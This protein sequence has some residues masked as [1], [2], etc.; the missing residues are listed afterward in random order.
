[1]DSKFSVDDDVS[2]QELVARAGEISGEPQHVVRRVLAAVSQIAHEG[3]RHGRG[4]FLFGLGKLESRQ[5]PAKLARHMVTG[6]R[7]MVPAHNA[8]VL[9]ASTSLGKAANQR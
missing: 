9:K 2:K 5:R 7:V 8:V 4:V 1:M 6:E 3:V